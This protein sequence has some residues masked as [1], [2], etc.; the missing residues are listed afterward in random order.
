MQALTSGIHLNNAEPVIHHF[1][2]PA[3]QTFA[4]L[5]HQTALRKIFSILILCCLFIYIGGYHLV[6]TFYQYNLKQEMRAYLQTHDDARY[7]TYLSFPVVKNKI[8]DPAFEWEETNKEFSYHGELYDVVAIKRTQDSIRICAMKDD[9]END[10]EKQMAGIRHSKQERDSN[11]VLSLMKF[12]SVF[13]QAGD[14]IV[15]LSR[16]IPVSY[17]VSPNRDYTSCH[18]EIHS[19]PPRG[20]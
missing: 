10:L 19:P 11:P 1:T 5:G 12:F 6:Y 17:C 8:A 4:I 2:K 20:C 7:G 9:R 13:E 14:E 3:F 15:F 16:K 18:T